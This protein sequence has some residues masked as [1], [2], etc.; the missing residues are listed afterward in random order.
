MYNT[1]KMI[2]TRFIAK[3]NL[4]L[5]DGSP[6]PAVFIK[7]DNETGLSMWDITEIIKKNNEAK[8]FK[9]GD[10]HYA[11]NPPHAIARCD[12]IKENLDL[13]FAKLQK[14]R[15]NINYSIVD[16]INSLHKDV[17][18]DTLNDP[19]LPYIIAQELINMSTFKK[20]PKDMK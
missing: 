6:A 5:K 1:Q 20:R 16:T 19:A 8:I 11:K 13:F 10:K 4:L 2:L 17:C 12:L 14:K 3:R 9:F 15:S 18:F 7:R